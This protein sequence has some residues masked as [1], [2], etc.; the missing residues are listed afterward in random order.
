MDKREHDV[1]MLLVGK[2]RCREEG[3]VTIVNQQ[4][5]L[6]RPLEETGKA[7]IGG[8]TDMQSLWSDQSGCQQCVWG[9]GELDMTHRI[10]VGCHHLYH[11]RE[12]SKISVPTPSWRLSCMEL[13]PHRLGKTHRC[14]YWSSLG[15]LVNP[16]FLGENQK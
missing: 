14:E 1:I 4:F 13:E 5:R 16:T 10:K 8:L 15:R 3:P 9:R 11:L 6:Q 2:R 12:P 7:N